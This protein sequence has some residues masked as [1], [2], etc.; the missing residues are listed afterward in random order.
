VKDVAPQL[1]PELQAAW[2][3]QQRLATVVA[4]FEGLCQMLSVGA[5]RTDHALSTTRFGS[6]Q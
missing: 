1:L 5:N 4:S 3:E 6:I 2:K